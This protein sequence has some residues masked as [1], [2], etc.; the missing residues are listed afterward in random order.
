MFPFSFDQMVRTKVSKKKGRS[1]DSESEDYSP[2]SEGQVHRKPK[3]TKMGMN[4]S[5]KRGRGTENLPGQGRGNPPRQSHAQSNSSAIG[6]PSSLTDETDDD[7]NLSYLVDS[8]VSI[9]RP[10]RDRCDPA[11]VNYKRGGNSIENLRYMDDPWEEEH[12]FHGDVCFWFP[13]QADWYE[14]VIMSYKH[15]TIEMKWID[16]GYLR[17][18]ASP[19]KEVV[20][21]VYDHCREMDL[22]DIMSFRCDWNEEVVAQF[23]DI[24]FIEENERVIHWH[25]GGKRFTYNMAEFSTLFGQTGNSVFFGGS[26]VV[27]RDDTKVDLHVGNELEP[28]MMHFMYDRAYGDIVYGQVKGL[29]PYYRLFN[30]LFRF[31]LTLRGVIRT[32]SPVE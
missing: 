3:S 7:I 22:V 28:S 13:H 25:L 19:V 16:W 10:N 24:L 11:M 32:I 1:T 4:K 29:T 26:Y 12:S 5:N 14:S 6:H 8:M 2:S 18:L 27:N 20:D 15:V 23:Y 9:R 30:T 21:A 17:R 31:T